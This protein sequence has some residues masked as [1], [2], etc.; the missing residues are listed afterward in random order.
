MKKKTKNHTA[1]TKNLDVEKK[2]YVIAVGRTKELIEEVD[3]KQ[4]NIRIE[5]SNQE[6]EKE[7]LKQ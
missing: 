2:D 7:Q 5:I 6:D 4:A 3:T 1:K